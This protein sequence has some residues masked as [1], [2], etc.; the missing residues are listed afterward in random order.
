MKAAEPS[1]PG[2]MLPIKSVQSLACCPPVL[3]VFNSGTCNPHCTLPRGDD[4]RID[5]LDERIQH[6]ATNLRILATGPCRHMKRMIGV[7]EQVQHRALAKLA[8]QWLKLVQHCERIA[9]ALQE[10]HRHLHVEQMLAAPR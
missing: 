8:T 7:L 6:L 3:L 4:H 5:P 1:A 9:R 10:Q 2:S